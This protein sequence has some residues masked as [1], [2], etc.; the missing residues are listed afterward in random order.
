MAR[1]FI[2]QKSLEFIGK[3]SLGDILKSF[4]LYLLFSLGCIFLG[5]WL[6]VHQDFRRKQDVRVK[7]QINRLQLVRFIVGHDLDTLASDLKILA[8]SE[9]LEKFLEDDSVQNRKALEQRMLLF[10]RDRKVFYQTRYIDAAGDEVI[11]VNFKDV[12]ELVPAALLQNKKERYYFQETLSRAKDSIFVSP[13]DLNIE[14]GI[15]EE[16]YVPVIRV[17]TPVFDGSGVKRGIVLLNF[18]AQTVLNRYKEAY[19]NTSDSAFSIV[20]RQGY[21]V[22]SDSPEREWGFMFGK[23]KRLAHENLQ[24]WEAIQRKDSS[25]LALP[26][27]FFTYATIYPARHIMGAAVATAVETDNKQEE[28]AWHLILTIP[29]NQLTYRFFLNQY[30][31]LLWVVPTLVLIV[32]IC[33]LYIA[34][35]RVRKKYMDRSLHLLSTAVEQSPASVIITDVEGNI[36]YAN[37]KFEQMSGYRSDEFIGQNP[38]IFKSGKTSQ[39]VYGDLWQTILSGEVWVGDFEN[40]NRDGTPYFVAAK[41]AP[42]FEKN[43]SISNLLALQEDVTEKRLLQQKLEQL[44]TTDGLTGVANRSHFL[45]VFSSEFI[46]AER[47]G[48]PLAVLAFDLDKFKT[49]NDTYGHHAGDEVLKQFAET[50]GAELRGNDYFGRL[51]GE[52]FSAILVGTEC[53]GAELLAERLRKRVEAQVVVFEGYRI[54]YTVSIGCSSWQRGDKE[55][56]DILKRADKALYRAKNLG[57]NRVELWTD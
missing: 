45:H 44:A 52:E 5:L 38:R 53:K 23:D 34:V 3:G 18:K 12:A 15:V 33:S 26:G 37:S 47:Y 24:L 29:K 36:Q 17:G 46:R 57:R 30:K 8:S 20:N 51:G 43:G 31:H 11:R 7:E 13:L 1:Q 35:L 16:P 28:L 41:V 9:P 19:P 21:W 10:A 2:E 14:N 56:E 50:I 27:G 6:V 22:L 40:K 4:L 54:S 25:Q 39:E 32:S 48:Q 42:M 49:I 55:S